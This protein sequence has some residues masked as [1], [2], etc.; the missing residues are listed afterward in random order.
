MDL[1]NLDTLLAQW[2]ETYKKGLLSFW[3]LLLLAQ[4]K[5]YQESQSSRRDLE[6]YR[7][8]RK[9][10]QHRRTSN[11]IRLPEALRRPQAFGLQNRLLPLQPGGCVA[12][13][14]E[15]FLVRV[16]THEGVG[17]RDERQAGPR[18]AADGLMRGK[19]RRQAHPQF[20]L[21]AAQA[22]QPV[23]LRRGG[24]RGG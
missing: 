16:K 17:R 2:E 22:Q 21:R 3:L 8:L 13:G 12:H 10:G 4:R 1:T 23:Q 19:H 6:S 14:Q 18:E 9:V 15:G 20:H 11:R 24:G 7:N 5:A